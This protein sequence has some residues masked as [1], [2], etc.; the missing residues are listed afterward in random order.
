MIPKITQPSHR[1]SCESQ[2]KAAKLLAALAIAG[3]AGQA[4]AAPPAANALPTGGKVV[5]GTAAISQAGNTMN[6]N[7]SSQRAV[8]NWNSFDVGSK[9][10]VNFNQPDSSAS[11]LNY[12]NSASKSMINGAVNANGQVIFVN[13]N[14]VVFG[15]GAEVNVGGMVAT[16]MNISA[17]E[18]MSGK[19]T[20]VYEG[21]TTGKIINK[22]H[23]TGN[24]INS[25]IA[26]MAPQVVNTGVI[27]ATMSGNNAIALVAGQKVTLKFSGSQFVSVSVDASVVNALI[28]NKLLINA[29]SGQ[30]IIGANAAQNLMGSLI[31]NTGTISASDINTSGGKISLTADTIEQSG[32]IEANS[33][34]ATG[35]NISLKGNNITL[36]SGSKTTATGAAAGG[37]I[38]VGVNNANNQSVQDAIQNNSLANTVSVQT[39]ATVDASASQNGNGGTIN[40]WSQI[41][42]LIAGNLFAKGGAQGGNGGFIETSSKGNVSIAASSITDTSA[43]KGKT[44]MWTIDPQALIIDSAAA[45]AISNALNSTSVTLDA[46]GSACAFGSCTASQSAL[47]R[48]MAGADIY[49]SNTA[50]SLNLIATGGQIDINSNI[51]AGQVYAVAQAINVN[52]SINTN[53]GNNSNIYLAGAIINILGN[54]NSN[55]SNSNNSN[56]TNSSNLNSANTTTANNRRNGQNGLNADSNTYTSNGGL[57]NILATGDINIGSNSYI[58]ANGINGGI[59]TIVSTAGKITINGIVDSIGKATNGGNIAIVGKTQADII[60]ALIG[61]EGVSQGGVINLGQ[62]NNLGNGTILA[63]PATAPPALTNFVNTALA[64]AVDSNNSITSSNIN[65]DSQ[66]GINA[67]NGTIVVFGDQIQINN[68]SLAAINGDIAIG[69]P[70][71]S[72]GAVA[73][74]VAISNSTLTANRVETSGDLLGTQNTAVVSNEWL[75]DPTT[76]TITAAASTGG[77]LASALAATGA[78]NI[79]TADIVAAINAGNTVNVVATGAITQTGALAF[80]PA[81]GITG[82]LILD[83]HLTQGSSITSSGGITS[84]G[85][86]TVNL[87]FL[88]GGQSLVSGAITAS[89]GPIN[90]VMQSYWRTNTTDLGSGSTVLNTAPITTRGGYVIMDGTGGTIDLVNQ[91]ITMGT[92]NVGYLQN[93]YPQASINTTTNAGVVSATSTGGN[94]IGAGYDAVS[95][96]TMGAYESGGATL[97]I[98]GFVNIQAKSAGTNTYSYIIAG[99]G[100][101][102]INAAGNITITNAS[103]STGLTRG[104]IYLSAGTTLTS[105]TGSVTISNNSTGS[106]SGLQILAP[107]AAATGITINNT[108]FNGTGVYSTAA[109]STT[110][111]AIT[112][113][114]TD[115]I[116]GYFAVNLTGSVTAPQVGITASNTNATGTGAS[117]TGGVTITA[118]TYATVGDALNITSTVATTG[119][120]GG[121]VVTG[122]AI[123]NNSNGG[124][125]TLVTNGDITATS[126]VSFATANTTNHVQT[127]T[128]DTRTGNL[129]SQITAGIFTFNAT[130]A[131]SK[132]N[133]QILSNGSALTVPAVTVSGTI[134]LDNTCASNASYTCSTPLTASSATTVNTTASVG[135][136]LT[137]AQISGQGITINGINA[138]ASNAAVALGANGLTVTSAASF[139]TAGVNA[140][141]VI[142]NKNTANIGN[143]GITSTGAL[144]V[145]SAG[146]DVLFQSNGDITQ[147]GGLTLSAN[148]TTHAQNVKYDTTSG[149]GG[150]VTIGAITSQ[151]AS[152]SAPVNVTVVATGAITQTGAWAFAPATGITDTLILD[153]H[154][155]Q[156]SSITSSGGITSSGAGTV[157]LQFLAGG[158]SLVSGAITASSGPINVVM[159]SYWTGNLS[160]SPSGATILNTAPITTRGGYVIM[161]GTGGTI[162]LVHQT[163]TMGTVNVGYIQNI[164]PQAS[165]NTT[166]NAGVVSATSTGGNFIG[167]GY[168]A[169]SGGTVGAYESSGATLNIG[170]FVNIQTK[171]A[172]TNNYGYVI[173]NYG[174]GPINAAGNITITANSSSTGIVGQDIYLSAGT[175]LTSYTGSV[176]I[177]NTSTGNGSGI[178]IYAAIS[179]AT[180]ITINNTNVGAIGVQ[181]NAAGTLTTTAGTI[182][183]TSTST[184]SGVYAESLAGL[185]TAPKVT[186]TGTNS[187]AG[188]LGASVTGGVTITAG[189]YASVGDALNITTTVGTNGTTGGINVTTGAITNN[190]NGGDVTFKTNGDITATSAVSF[191]TANTTNHP[192]TITYDTTSGNLNSQI[193]TGSFT[194]APTGAISPVNYIQ[195]ASGSVLTVG[196]LSVSGSITIDNTFGCSGSGCTP[197]S[198][199]LTNGTVGSTTVTQNAAG[200]I[201]ASNLTAGGNI[202]INGVWYGSTNSGGTLNLSAGTIS[203]G[204]NTLNGPGAINLNLLS[205]DPANTSC[206]LIATGVITFNSGT[207]SIAGGGITILGGLIGP[208]ASANSAIYSTSS[209]NNVVTMNAYSSNINIGTVAQPI[210]AGYV[211]Y[212]DAF[213]VLTATG[214]G[215]SAG[216]VSIYMQA[217]NAIGTAFIHTKA[218]VASNAVTIVASGL[219][220]TVLSQTG[221]ITANS[222]SVTGTG[223]TAATVVSLGAM[224][225]NAGGTDIS[226]TGNDTAAGGNTGITQT[227][228]ITQNA[229]GGNIT[230]TSN[231]AISQSGAVTVAPNTSGT[232][233]SI[234]YDT[235]NG[236]KNSII[237]AGALTLTGGMTGS[238]SRIDYTMKSSGASI[239][240]S[241]AITVPGSIT[242]D[243]TYLSGGDNG[244]TVSNSNTYSTSSAYGVRIDGTLTAGAAITVQGVNS[245]VANWNGN[246]AIQT[247]NNI[248]ILSSQKFA[249]NGITFNGLTTASTGQPLNSASTTTFQ[250]GTSSIVGGDV[251]FAMYN[252]GGNSAIYGGSMPITAYGA[253]VNIGT[254]A[255]PIY[256]GAAI[257]GGL[258]AI[259][260]TKVAGVGGNVSMYGTASTA[261]NAVNI[262]SSITADG[263]ITILGN[264]AL[265]NPGSNVVTLGSTITLTSATNNSTLSV[266]GKTATTTGYTGANTG[267][268]VTGNIVDNSNG[269]NIS[270]ISNGV[271]NQT[272]TTTVAPNTSGTASYI[273]YNTTS[274]NQLSTISTGALTIGAGTSSSAINYI[275]KSSGSALTIGATTVPGYILV[276]NTYGCTGASCTPAS[277]YLNM[278]TISTSNAST[279]VYVS[280][281]LSAGSSITINGAS[282]SSAAGTADGAVTLAA[283]TISG[284]QV[285][286]GNQINISGFSNGASAG[287]GLAFEGNVTINSGTGPALVGGDINVLAVTSA[288]ACCSGFWMNPTAVA[289]VSANAYG[290]SINFGTEATPIKGVL[291]INGYAS[292]FNTLRAT[293]VGGVGG[294]INIYAQS[295]ASGYSAAYIAGTITADANVVVRASKTDAGLA[296]ALNLSAAIT[297]NNGT[298]SVTGTTSSA[299][300]YGASITGVINGYA[301][302][303]IFGGPNGAATGGGVS[304]TATITSAAGP[305]SITGIS[306]TAMAVSD[307]ALITGNSITVTGT[308]TTAAT[309]VSLGAMTIN[310]CSAGVACNSNNISVTG[311][312]TA[313]GGN[314]GIT[315]TG[316]ITQNANGGSIYFISNNQI[317][318]AGNISIAQNTSGIDSVISYNTTNGN[319]LS[320]INAGA[321]TFL[322]TSTSH[323]N[324]NNIASGAPIIVNSALNVP[325][326]ITFDNTYL[327]GVQGGINA[328]NAWQYGTTAANGIAITCATTVACGSLT[329]NYGIYLRGVV[330]ASSSSAN[331]TFDAVSINAVAPLAITSS[332]TFAAGTDAINIVGITPQFVV[333]TNATPTSAVKGNAIGISGAVTI[334][335]NSTGGNTNIVAYRGRYSDA[336]TI[337]NASTAGALE[338]SAI[339]TTADIVTIAGTTFTQNSNAGVFIATS[340]N[341]NVTPPKII[342]NGTGPVVIEAGAT[343]PVGTV[344]SVCSA[345]DCGQITALSG[346]NITSPNGGVYLYAGSPGTTAGTMTTPTTLAYLNSTLGTLNFSNTLFGQAYA[347]GNVAATSLPIF[348]LGGLNTANVASGTGYSTF[349]TGA[350]TSTNYGPVIQF[351]IAPSVTVKLSGEITKVYGTVD[352]LATAGNVAVSGS[353]DNQLNSLFIKDAAINP[354]Y[355]ANGTGGCVSADGCMKLTVN[356]LNFVLPLG[357]FI[358]SL[359]A[360]PPTGRVSYG[361]LAG[362]QVNGTSSTVFTSNYAYSLTSTHGALIS[363]GVQIAVS[364]YNG[365]SGL[366]ITPVPLTIT[367]NNATAQVNSSANLSTTVTGLVNT[368]VDGV[369]ITDTVNATPSLVNAANLNTSGTYAGSCSTACPA[370]TTNPSTINGGIKLAASTS[371]GAGNYVITYVPGTLTVTSDAVVTV[372]ILADSKVYGNSTT[373]TQA[374]GY[375]GSGVVTLTGLS[376]SNTSGT[377]SSTLCGCTISGLPANDVLTGLT[378]T[379]LGGVTTAGVGAGSVGGGAYTITG[380]NAVLGGTGSQNVIWQYVSGLMTVTPR[381]V[382]I[383]ANVVNTTYGSAGTVSQ[384]SGQSGGYVVASPGAGTGLIAG[385]AISSVA[386]NYYNGSTNSTT[387]PGTLGANTY[388][389]AIIPSAATGTG[390]FNSTNYNITYTPANLVVNKLAVSL[391]ANSQSTVYGT[392]LAL[393]TT[394]YTSSLSS[395]P[396]GDTISGVTLQYNSSATVPGTTNALTYTDGIVASSATG[397]GGFGATNYAITYS[398]GNLTVTPANVVIT[399]ANVSASGQTVMYNGAAQT[400]NPST[401]FT[402]TG[403]QNSQAL[404]FSTN[405]LA[406]GLN[407]GTYANTITTSGSNPTVTGV[408]NGGLLSNYNISVSAQGSLTITSAPLTVAGATSNVA[409]NGSLQNNANPVVSGLL[410]IDTQSGNGVTV[411]GKS[412]GTNAGTYNDALSVTAAGATQLSNY[413]ITKTNGSLVISKLAATV[414]GATTVN[415]YTGLLQTNTYTTTGILSGDTANVTIAGSA[416]ATHVSQGTVPDVF[417]VSGS[418][419]GNYAFTYAPGSITITPVALSVFGANT[420][421]VYNATT[422][423]NSVATVTGLKASDTATIGGSYG[424]GKNVGTYADALTVGLSNSSDYTIGV[425]NGSITITPATI[426]IS[427][428]TANNKVYNATTAATLNI[429]TITYSGVFAGDTV[430]VNTS[431]LSGTFVDK[432]VGT[433]KTVNISGVVLGGS[434]SA[435]YQLSGGANTTTTANITPA[436]LTITG[437]NLTTTYNGAA[438]S[439]TSPTVAGVIAGDN[440]VVATTG[441]TGT[442]AGVYATSYAASGTDAGNYTVTSNTPTLTINKA[443]LVVT[444]NN[445]ATIYGQADPTLTA[446]VSGLQ[447]SDTSAVIDPAYVL[448]RAAGVNAGTYAITAAG[449]SAVTNYNITYV[450]AQFTIAQAGALLI[451]LNAATTTYGTAA[452]PTIASVQYVNA[453]TLTNFTNTGNTYTDGLGTTITITPAITGATVTSNVGAYANAVTGT[454]T[455]ATTNYTSVST[456]TNTLT[457]TPAPLT[458]T[459]ADVSKTYNANAVTAAQITAAS[460]TGGVANGVTVTSGALMNGQTIAGLGGVVYTGPAVGAINASSTPYAINGSVGSGFSNYAVTVVPGA[461]TVN[462]APLVVNGALTTRTYNGTL[463]TNA[464]ATIAGLQ[465][466][467][468]LTVAGLATGTH[469]G[470]TADALVATGAAASNYSITYNNGALTINPAALLV[471]GANNQYA[472]NGAL[473][474]NTGAS[475]SGLKGSDTATVAGYATATHVAQGIVPDVLV[476]TVSNSAD[477]T[478]TYVQGSLQITPIVITAAVNTATVMYNAASQTTGFVVTGL[479]G[480]DTATAA[481]GTATGTN[482]GTYTSNLVLNTS[483]DYTVGAITNGTLTITPAPLTISGGLTAN[484]KVY[485]T[486]N[487]ATIGV[488]GNQTLA[489][490]LGTDAVTVSST[491]PYTG[492][493]FTQSNVGSGLTVTPATTSS[494]INGASY[495][496]MAGVTLGGAAAGN[497]YVT[498]VGPQTLTA[499]ITPAPLT[500][501]SGL[502]ANNKAYDG[503]TAATISS[504]TQTLA[505][506]LVSDVGN[507]AI[508][509]SGPYTGAFSQSNVGTGLAVSASTTPTTIAGGTYNAMTGVT[510]SGSAQGNYYVAGLS[511]PIAANI[512]PYIIN[513]GSGSGPNIAAVANNKVYTSTTAANGS[514]S[515]VPFGTD[516]VSV[517]YTSAAFASPNVATGATVTFN[518]VTLSGASAA[519]YSIGS[520]PVTATA[521]ITPALL[522]ITA[523]DKSS[524]YSQGLA[525][526]TQAPAIGLLGSDTVTGATITTTATSTGANAAVGTYPITI[527]AATGS[528]LSNYSISYVPANYTIVGPGALVITT[529]GVTTPYG[530]GTSGNILAPALPTASYTS[531]L[532]GVISSLTYV[533]SST[534][535]KVTSYTFRDASNNDVTFNLAPSNVTTS[536]S[537]NI[538]VG[539]YAY[540]ASNLSAVATGLTSAIPSG[541]FTVTPLAVTITAPAATHAYNGAVQ[542][543]LAATASPAILT[544]DLVTVSGAASGK[545]VGVYGSNLATSGLDAGNYNFTYVNAN[546]TITPF[547]IGSGGSGAPSIAATANNKVYDTTTVASGALAMTN[548]FAGDSV[549]VAY[550]SAAFASPNVANGLTVSFSGVTLSGAAA[551][552]YSVASVPT[553]TANITPAPLTISAGLTA[554]NKVYDTT[555]AATIAVT[556]TQSLAG[557]LGTDVVSVSSTGPYTGATFSQSNVGSGL[558]VTPATSVV[559]GVTTMTGVT[560]TGAAANNYYVAGVGP[561]TLVANITP[562]PLTINAGLTANNKAYD[563]TTAATIS[564]ASQT[565]V[566]VLAADLNNVAVSSSGPYNATFASKNVANGITVTPNTTPTV[567]AGGTY[568]AMSGV[569]LSGSAASNYY[570]TGTASPI[571]ANITPYI[572]N[573]GSGTGPNITAVADSKVYTSTNTANGALSMVNLFP[574]DS[575][576]VSYATATFASSNVANGITVTFNTPTLSGASAANYSIGS[577]AITAPANITPAPLTITAVNKSSF[578]SQALATLT[579]APAV[580]LLGSD[581]VT[582]A[583]ISTTASTTGVNASAGNYPIAISAATGSGI[584]NYAITYVPATYTIVAPGA[585]MITTAGATT[586]YGTSTSGN[587]ITPAQPVASYSTGGSNISALTFVSAATVGNVTSYVYR[588]ATSA[589]VSFNLIPTGTTTST[590][591]N[592]VVGS[593]AYAASNLV[594]ASSGLTSGSA[595]ASGNLTVTPLTVTI[596]APTTAALTYNGQVQT[597]GPA[598]ASPAILTNDLVTVSGAASGK[599]VGVYGSNL[600]VSGA[601]ASNYTFTLVN[602][603]ITITPYVVTPG[604]TTGPR[605][606]TAANNKVYD[607]TTSATGSLAMAGLFPG[608]SVAVNYSSAAFASANVNLPASPQTVTFSGVTLSGASASN[609][610]I[611]SG[612][613]TATANITPAP[614]T[615]RGLVANNKVY[616]STTADVISGTPIVTGLLGSDTSTATGTAVGTF[617]SPNVANGISVAANLSGMTL[618]NSNYV[619]TGLT[620]PL[621]ANITP[622][623]LTISSGLFAQNKVYDTTTAGIIAAIGTQTLAG[624]LGSDAANLAVSSSGPYTGSFSQAS[625]GNGLTVSQATV[626]TVING[627]SYT[628]M[629]GVTLSGSAAGNYYVTGPTTALTANITK[630]PLTIT[631]INQA[632]FV[633]Q[634]IGALTYA[635]IGLLGSDTISAVTLATAASNIQPAGQYAITASNATGAAIGNYQVTYAPGTYTIVPAGQL[636]IQ[637]SG[638]VTPYTTAATFANPTVAYATSSGAVINNLYLTAS[639]TVNGITT[640]TYS[641]GAGASL[642]FNFAPKNPVISGS[643]NVSVGTYGL[644]AANFVITGNNIT[645]ISPVVTGDLTVTPR[646]I[647]IIATPATYVYNGTV[648]VLANNAATAG[649]VAGDLVIVADLTGGKNVGNYFSA[650]TTTGVDAKNYQAS[651]VN[652]NLKITPY[653]LGSGVGGPAISATAN[654]KV[655]NST[656]DATG[657]L[658][659]TG[660][661]PGDVVAVNFTSAAFSSPAVNNGVTVTFSGVALSGADAANYILGPMPVTATANITPVPSEPINNMAVLQ[662]QAAAEAPQERPTDLIKKGEIIYVRDKD[663]LPEYMQAIEVPSSGAFKFPV[664][665]HIIQELIN[666]SGENISVAGV[667]AKFGGYKLLMLPK[668]SRLVV[669]L[670]DDAPLPSGIRYDATSKNFT[671]PK[672]GEVKLPLSV[673]VTLM[674]GNKVLSEKIMVVTK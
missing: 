621:A 210:R 661:F 268:S 520:T 326:S 206:I 596:T 175:A 671:V 172:G 370:G 238:S 583:T 189:T 414:T 92:V 198:G 133:Y 433:A 288:P 306:T 357:D 546:L 130:G 388:T 451:N 538:T 102:P 327:A 478:V 528:G 137:G 497:Y 659:M 669:T 517:S 665:D 118:G 585:L 276:D 291:G 284:S 269:G 568:N 151:G 625:I 93:I 275:E 367:A 543:Q 458:L 634:P 572:I 616:T 353:L 576:A 229:N 428:I 317:S 7:Q 311:N 85:A 651:F 374:L 372:N 664:P 554:N 176:N 19:D 506:V 345:A 259:V 15:K 481:S 265:A 274:G 498:G 349:T 162:D 630:A 298:V 359:Q 220:G 50:T 354:G 323:I 144:A 142:G 450:P 155:T 282:A 150:S 305:V 429:G 10:T 670:P 515:M 253:N 109:I 358:N 47:I 588:D 222:I 545:N 519:N 44:G 445:A 364:G 252:S 614:V 139:P 347:T 35:G 251:N 397:T 600:A 638:A 3:L 490:V 293:T 539:S 652:A 52:G 230:F 650:L 134:L 444:A 533:S 605:L 411:T 586:P 103:T 57:I 287:H 26:L 416:A 72:Q 60:A 412:S 426:T 639:S 494:V 334:T 559:N 387:I 166:T 62:V 100:A 578:Y 488:T 419:S 61:S 398:P 309:V 626:T 30:V 97:N 440:V 318:Q 58:S 69:R 449:P 529:A 663:N 324:Y 261:Y 549:S 181:S 263:N 91:T 484:N 223:T 404:V 308:G 575:V 633:T 567:I 424:A 302:V 41:K 570:V 531:S 250:S 541:N 360:L 400:F 464:A 668:G 204:Q 29:G 399:P 480:T 383:T 281:S 185:I 430:S 270:F 348:T 75:L 113:N 303:T 200:A 149:N 505:G 77:T 122:G 31:K 332:G 483:S 2:F 604:S 247:N 379:S 361:T 182:S 125:V 437:S 489:G 48:I 211:M 245:G 157:N 612:A 241:G 409:Y 4:L 339:G 264:N 325:G 156:G 225:I 108:N 24:N 169:A 37:T 344:S 49:S 79:S 272:G 260:A 405:G 472:Y 418:A 173:Y 467:D 128:Y 205:Y 622:A 197:T 427:G 296:V 152:I 571:T 196:T 235:T 643:N 402:V 460:L 577:T 500:I 59:I 17:T 439:L 195:K 257:N 167:A 160:S 606:T 501:S 362:E 283:I 202:T 527:S 203:A 39:N 660:L 42:T 11:T 410:G 386:V 74:L 336:V 6:I 38:N 482:V 560:L 516:S 396:N 163:I 391:T 99:Y 635:S 66:T 249:G 178:T 278:S 465:G 301:G 610:S 477:Y 143:P 667:P 335:N 597:Q 502:T 417:S 34:Q 56:N 13:N 447:G 644:S 403:M 534:T 535:L 255:N 208:G 119:L 51:T 304:D 530:T 84:S 524:F 532:G 457:I 475:V 193:T 236:N 573:F 389:G 132:V 645:N 591:G 114:S 194:Y 96:G 492:A 601:D 441:G 656:T 373:T 594:S 487:A 180:G 115:N 219:T 141:S 207:S 547:I 470:T 468:T 491:G 443:A 243:N 503:T 369:T 496:T 476:A 18:F 581:T 90:V 64:A 537:G 32:V 525:T 86:G 394:A 88:A 231:N 655:Y 619:I 321:V 121:I 310:A 138:S 566:G 1:K 147:T 378:L 14:G 199:Y 28:S 346:N 548:L 331:Q 385:D 190:S 658:A 22:G 188:G 642:S 523:V 146:G 217:T 248:S 434:S 598:V 522:T 294:N 215:A 368:V 16:T 214:T 513:F 25:Y 508:S 111:G 377:P 171:T 462:T 67:P 510:L 153:N 363:S 641:D 558:T 256:G 371:T 595:I 233:S 628:T 431:N 432:N 73:S 636:L 582:G 657:S 315:Q 280:G 316:A 459:V 136:S 83:N 106:G 161:D 68:S 654:N 104:G 343:L 110:S 574:G 123:T 401:G 43:P 313:A 421:Q 425:T 469:A 493:T 485:D 648:R 569:T 277:G 140:I 159:Q 307:T 356:T 514:L 216:N 471:T 521:N 607:T 329:A 187:T 165:I 542:T 375:N 33:A 452:T 540:A 95:G 512:T 580:G 436:P 627:Q 126:A 466:S 632:S 647:T 611:A 672:L 376:L 218:I 407:V 285:R 120:A 127:L 179:A 314:T 333:T 117:L 593:Y 23:I 555:N 381:P 602:K 438:Q 617:A 495:T 53:G 212:D 609:Y 408:T 352:P 552:N 536:T 116:A 456:I 556:G 65:L 330:G 71:Y 563:G 553:A 183:I 631:A 511:A 507:V 338:L 112:I 587:I 201:L 177:S 649:I 54:I 486:T 184:G 640:Y 355:L 592:I 267:I 637:S 70:S 145:Q 228:A 244:I 646:A 164:Y 254:L 479:K 415:P 154:L 295:Y 292:S 653:V 101:G 463:Q 413:T 131:T 213:G 504:A 63:P 461:L 240:A 342:N 341:G 384:A 40:I 544:N 258:G 603:N 518:G 551:A 45:S 191:A 557:V 474:T 674:R 423:T 420:T 590:S 406:S 624:T 98:G 579:Q 623:P 242:L 158:Q 322:G 87:Q 266:T 232:T 599:N 446:S 170:G 80:A 618:S 608:D 337:T 273:T 392:A 9:A 234:T 226:V 246:A 448:T 94:F 168:A 550:T 366:V 129:N 5:A 290:S 27:T 186:I 453:G 148:T 320:T 221:A 174:A 615:I 564:S 565:L 620:A 393:G 299:A 673:K 589:L 454:Y 526:L 237:T 351:R 36:A 21:G 584:G 340:N 209:G 227:G 300:Y 509:S 135:I 279:G 662:Q 192:Q 666:L 76:V 105:Y 319:Q 442:N 365:S 55:G 289:K 613:I 350:A 107:I 473:Q 124:S 562:A 499:N 8:I 271:I 435:N 78:S 561:Q 224:T 312:D 82:T 328:S 239:Y 89:S 395:L 12:V 455:G 382:S 262:G 422:Q 20:Q 286:A 629:A 46:T 81:T 297:S 390:G 380:S